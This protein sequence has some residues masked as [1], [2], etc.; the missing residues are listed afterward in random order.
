MS[1]RWPANREAVAKST[2][3]PNKA[4]VGLGF[5]VN[6]TLTL[7]PSPLTHRAAFQIHVGEYKLGVATNCTELIQY[8]NA[9][10]CITLYGIN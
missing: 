7:N 1:A 5:R 6:K 8:E 10:V 4:K 2:V 9:P 3:K